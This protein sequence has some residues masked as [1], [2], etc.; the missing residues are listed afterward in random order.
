MLLLFSDVRSQ[1]PSLR[2]AKNANN[3]DLVMSAARHY[4]NAS[5]ALINQPIERELLRDSLLVLL[6][7]ISQTTDKR[8]YRRD[9]V[10]VD[11]MNHY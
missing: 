5:L 9:D 7:C 11:V 3:Y 10:R 4:W 8:K 2:F 1:Y 6:Q